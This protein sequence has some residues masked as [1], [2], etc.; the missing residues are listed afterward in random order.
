M[1]EGALLY[2]R[3]PSYHFVGTSRNSYNIILKD[4]NYSG[5]YSNYSCI[6]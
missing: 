2:G 1:T 4:C 5:Q 6:Q 3:T